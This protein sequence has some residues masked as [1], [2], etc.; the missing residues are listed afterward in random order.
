[1]SK[2]ILANK[3]VI[4]LLQTSEKIAS[5]CL[6]F[7]NETKKGISQ[8]HNKTMNLI[9]EIERLNGKKEAFMSVLEMI[10]SSNNGIIV[11]DII[12]KEEIE[13]VKAQIGK[14]Q[15]AMSWA[16]ERMNSI[17]EKWGGKP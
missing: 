5:L 3:I 8:D 2:A 6:E 12:S 10:E 7:E 15:G 1:M 14:N 9:R 13:N 17:E 11:D 16:K 4:L